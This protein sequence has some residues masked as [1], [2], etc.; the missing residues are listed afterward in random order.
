MPHL[1]VWHIDR[2]EIKVGNLSKLFHSI[3]AVDRSLA[4]LLM[5]HD[6]ETK[7]YD[8]GAKRYTR[9]GGVFQY[10]KA[11]EAV[12]RGQVLTSVPWASWDSGI[13]V[14]NASNI[15]AVDTTIDV[16]T[17]TTAMTANQYKGYWIRQAA[18][19]GPLGG[20]LQ[21]KS[22][23]AIAASGE[24]ELTMERAVG[25]TI[26]NDKALE[27]FNP[28]LVEVVDGTTEVIKGVAPAAFTSGQYGWMQVGGFVPAVLVGHSSSLA[29]VLNE[30][31]VPLATPA[32]SCQ[33]MA[34]ATEPDI[35]ELA[36]SPLRA[37]AAV[38]ADIVC[39]IPAYM[40]CDI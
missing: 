24:G 36:A 12:T 33:G 6:S 16:D 35:M 3:M 29:V 8:L 18:A 31:L 21:I 2:K 40:R 37:L 25:E 28:Y 39:Y 15:A 10:V 27:I 1:R 11:N 32:G 7:K 9:N 13:A 26:A 34:G 5:E 38:A 22:H 20:A 14:N 19:A 4:D 30:P 23:P 17:V